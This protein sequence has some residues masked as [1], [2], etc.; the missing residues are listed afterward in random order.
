VERQDDKW[1][2]R[3]TMGRQIDEWRAGLTEEKQGDD[4]WKVVTLCHRRHSSEKQE[5]RIP[6]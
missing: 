6:D 4:K 5:S 3:M 2:D 1:R